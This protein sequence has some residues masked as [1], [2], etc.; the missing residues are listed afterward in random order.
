[1]KTQ[2]QCRV[3]SEYLRQPLKSL[4]LRN[5]ETDFGGAYSWE[6]FDTKASAK[7]RLTSI[8]DNT[9]SINASLHKDTLMI[10]NI[11]VYI[12]TDKSKFWY[13]E[14]DSE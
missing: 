10:G 8:Y 2:I 5:F 12:C 7:E 13:K 11:Q 9:E 14:E 4:N 6:D 3:S 1:M